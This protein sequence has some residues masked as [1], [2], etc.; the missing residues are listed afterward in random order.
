M[1]RSRPGTRTF[2]V[3]TNVFISAIKSP[4]RE[5]ESLRLLLRMIEDPDLKLIGDE[6][7]LEEMLHYAELLRSETSVLLL[8]ALLGK[9]ELVKTSKRHVKICKTYI[10]TP[11]ESDVL[12]AAA[13][14]QTGAALVT[15]DRHFDRIK[16]EG[17]IEVLSVS[18]AI[19]RL[20]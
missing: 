5:T 17:I 7:L 12:H 20:L 3:D 10:R 18:E 13:C 11:D 9:M 14:L 6:S 1:R 2:L 8:S 19:K 4:R 16:R 15:N